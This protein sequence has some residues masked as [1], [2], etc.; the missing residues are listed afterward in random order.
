MSSLHPA[1]TTAL[2]AMI[3]EKTARMREK[4][5]LVSIEGGHVIHHD[6]PAAFLAPV[7]ALLSTLPR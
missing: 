6:S 1:T 3:L 5:T 4:T 7:K 2:I